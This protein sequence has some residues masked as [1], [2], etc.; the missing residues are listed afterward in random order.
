[1]NLSTN[2]SGPDWN[3]L[4]VLI[5]WPATAV[6][7]GSLGLV[8]V[9]TKLRVSSIPVCLCGLTAVH[10]DVVH[11]PLGEGLGVGLQVAQ[12][13]GEALAGLVTWATTGNSKY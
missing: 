3:P 12:T 6:D 2:E 10:L 4:A 7:H 13:A 8:E 1:M 9:T 11:P 5:I